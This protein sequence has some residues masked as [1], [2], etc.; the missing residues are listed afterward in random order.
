MMQLKSA[1]SSSARS[2]AVNASLDT[3]NLLDEKNLQTV[4][5]VAECENELN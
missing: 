4:K 3:E 5:T 1:K 2:H